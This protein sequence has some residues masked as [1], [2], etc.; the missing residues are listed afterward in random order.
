ML[1]AWT[2]A[3]CKSSS[4]DSDVQPLL[5]TTDLETPWKHLKSSSG[6]IAGLWFHIAS[7]C[8]DHHSLS[9]PSMPWPQP[10]GPSW[11]LL[12]YFA[13]LGFDY[14]TL[15][16]WPE[17]CNDDPRR[18]LWQ[19]QAHTHNHCHG[20]PCFCVPIYLG[21]G[22]GPDE[23][24][25]KCLLKSGCRI[26]TARLVILILEA[27]PPIPSKDPSP[28]LESFG[29]AC[30]WEDAWDLEG[31]NGVVILFRRLWWSDSRL[32]DLCS[33]LPGSSG[34]RTSLL[35]FINVHSSEHFCDRSSC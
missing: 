4:G 21:R 2:L 11:F 18:R 10:L 23:F 14:S 3:F 15:D 25:C 24:S 13:P 7:T 29:L 12:T 35:Q 20:A 27:S 30:Q 26:K 8:S 31:G 5:R 17:Y 33:T 19:S 32:P 9:N 1:G 34:W 22:I 16:F 28:S 6:S